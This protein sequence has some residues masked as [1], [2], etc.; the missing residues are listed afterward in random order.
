[1]G[2]YS[3]PPSA[4][5]IRRVQ[6][7]LTSD[8]IDE[9][10]TAYMAG[11]LVHDIAVRHGVHRSTVMDHVTR[12][13]LPRRSNHGWTDQE[14]QTAADL[15]AAGQSLAA[16]G[17]HFGIDPTTVANRFQRAGLPIRARRGWT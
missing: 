14:L 1:M 4:T 12:R 2:R 17:Q 10:L 13:R 6:R 8:D 11:D 5:S 7:R 16:V 9:I 15:Y 3:N